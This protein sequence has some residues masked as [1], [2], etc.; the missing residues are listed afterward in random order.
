M[1]RPKPAKVPARRSSSHPAA[2]ASAK[3]IS[4]TV[5]VV[6][7]IALLVAIV[8]GRAVDNQFVWQDVAT[9]ER[10][11]TPSVD[12]LP[13][14]RWMCPPPVDAS[15]LLVRGAFSI[16]H[17]LWGMS[18]RGYHIVNVIAHAA[19]ALLFWRLLALLAVPG[20]GLAAMIFA[21]HPV[22]VAS[23]DWV[24]A[25]STVFSGTLCL[26][27]LVAF[28]QSFTARPDNARLAFAG[29]SAVEYG[30]ALGLYVLALG[31]DPVSVA[32]PVVLIVL[33]WWKSDRRTRRNL[34]SLAP[35][36]ALALLSMFVPGRGA[37]AR[38][39]V[40]TH[41][42]SIASVARLAGRSF[43]LY[44]GK[45]LWPDPFVL[46]DPYGNSSL[47]GWWEYVPFAGVLSL[48]GGLWWARA[49]IGRGPCA[50][51]TI[52][53]LV[54]FAQILTAGPSATAS[55]FIADH[56]AYH[57]SLVACAIVGAAI[58][59]TLKRF[60]LEKPLVMAAVSIAV[61]APL[62]IIAEQRTQAFH[63]RIALNRDALLHNPNAWM[64]HHDLASL[65]RDQGHLEE[66]IQSERLAIESLDRRRTANPAD[67]NC[68]D[69]VAG[70][71]GQLASLL[72][73]VGKTADANA[74][75]DQAIAI[76]EE[77]V[78]QI[79]VVPDYRDHLAWNYA[80]RAYAER[81]GGK[82]ND[83]LDWFR[84]AVAEQEIVVESYPARYSTQNNLATNY[85]DIGII[86]L[87]Q[88]LGL[89]AKASFERARDLRERLV[90]VFPHEPRYRDGLA[91]CYVDL[92]LV[93][94]WLAKP[95]S[96]VRVLSNALAL[97]EHLVRENPEVA[98]YQERLA[99]LYSDI[100]L[101]ER[102]LENLAD[103][104]RA[105]QSALE[106]RR[107]L[108]RRYPNVDD[109]QDNLAANYVDI[110][111]I[112][113]ARGQL[114][115]AEKSCREAI[116]VRR[117]LSLRQP[118]N[119]LYAQRLA[120]S[121]VELSILLRETHRVAESLAACQQAVEICQKLVQNAPDDSNYQA[122]LSWAFENLG[123]TQI[124]NRAT[125][126]ATVSCSMAVRISEELVRKSGDAIGPRTDLTRA[127]SNLA[128]AQFANGQVAEAEENHRA[129]I[130][131]LAQLTQHAPGVDEYKHLTAESCHNLANVLRSS[132]RVHGAAAL[133]QAAI[134]IH[135]SLTAQKS[136]KKY[137]S[138][139]IG[140]LTA[141]A[142]AQAE[143][144]HW[145]DSA[146]AYAKACRYDHTPESATARTLLQ[147][148]AGDEAGYR[149]SCGRLVREYGNDGSPKSS[150]V[151]ALA[152]VVGK[153]EI[154]DAK[155][156]C[157]IA[158]HAAAAPVYPGADILVAAA[159]YRAGLI[160]E[161]VTG[162]NASLAAINADEN[163]RDQAFVVRLIGSLL[164][165]DACH[166]RHD[167]VALDAELMRLDELM[168]E[169]LVVGNTTQNDG[170]PD[171]SVRWA[172]EVTRRELAS[173]RQTLSSQSTPP[174]EFD[175][176][177]A[178]P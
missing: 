151:I 124:D 49:K 66:A 160:G 109:Y 46:V 92:S 146:A 13:S 77:L 167:A 20:A 161:A 102:Q 143:M 111:S 175:P 41:G 29:R 105:F 166:Q 148:A 16:Q 171:W 130:E 81:D 60:T 27:T 74:A 51:T 157:E 136:L 61:I 24:T 58:A 65:L 6:L 25:A 12:A 134:D 7:A 38:S 100:G 50:A 76:R 23:V 140:D 120:A 156:A 10:H 85:V 59:W 107:R 21:V 129:A 71:Y 91:W 123:V 97:R 95:E 158:R 110:G 82:P 42:T 57:A 138:S 132:G 17:R 67:S 155:A 26:A 5:V 45:M 125:A 40:A 135:E 150:F 169:S 104:E 56:I 75:R 128:K 170:L 89:E 178:G 108:A 133:Y 18:P 163:A 93:E 31:T 174:A 142:D 94:S 154:T 112:Q 37:D 145:A 121:Y 162:L 64:A 34:V 33:Q 78:R 96:A 72:E 54:L 47:G 2:P 88:N 11:V 63:D 83:A 69:D 22:C 149:E 84:K 168:I 86:E 36:A 53:G 19:N 55:L 172:V 28:W 39:L 144:G 80:D 116:A 126:A 177:D 3:P 141:Y 131:E 152:L 173:L 159:D 176:A 79:P 70:C 62:A 117:Q 44:A 153:C 99:V 52:F 165:A 115:A 43:W 139:L 127:L 8:Y 9:I 48:I 1:A 68:A 113:H 98:E 103:A 35:F 90:S 14:E 164:A 118:G 73:Q 147:L 119:G 122:A 101:K 4:R 106:L 87:D 137:Q 114:A 15:P 30:L 32:L